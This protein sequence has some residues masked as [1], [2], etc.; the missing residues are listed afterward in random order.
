MHKRKLGCVVGTVLLAGGAALAY[1][2]GVEEYVTDTGP[3][4]AS[5]H[6]S[7]TQLQVRNLLPADPG[8]RDIE[9]VH[10]DA[11]RSGQGTYK[12]LTSEQRTM[13]VEQVQAL[14]KKATVTVAVPS[15][16]KPNETLEIKATVLGGNGPVVG[17]MLVDSDLRY[18]ARP[19]ASSGWQILKAPVVQGPDGQPQTTWLDKRVA[20]TPRNLN[21]IQVYGITPATTQSSVV[22]YTLKAPSAPGTY[23]L[24][25][26][27]LYGVELGTELGTVADPNSPVG[28]GPRGGFGG[29]SGR[30]KFSELQTV[31]VR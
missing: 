21:F 26:A 4:C 8:R 23:P 25:V 19:I 13:L 17:V 31:A 5:C 30:V 20:G 24:A 11:I 22:T 10:Y 1:P 27:L 7:V 14:D 9:K 18:Q 29:R 15:S 2:G 12:E 16:V 28:K 6:S 3:F